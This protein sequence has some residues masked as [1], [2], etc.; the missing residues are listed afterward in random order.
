MIVPVAVSDMQQIEAIVHGVDLPLAHTGH[1]NAVLILTD[2]QVAVLWQY[3]ILH[4]SAC[5]VIPA[6]AKQLAGNSRVS[7]CWQHM[8]SACLPAW[9][10]DI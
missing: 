5:A 9:Q 3:Q 7:T 8:I 10:A 6:Y 2:L 1:I 4:N